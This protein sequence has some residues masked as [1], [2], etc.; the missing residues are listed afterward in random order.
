MRPLTLLFVLGL[1]M[2]AFYACQE[3]R[4]AV[5]AL[6]QATMHL[7][8]EAMKGM[9]DLNRVSRGLKQRLETLDSLAPQRSAIKDALLQIERAD[10]DMNNWMMQYQSPTNLKAAEAQAYLNGQKTKIE[11]NWADIKA[12][13]ANG[14]ALLK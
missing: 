13:I 7:H 5:K 1:M 10:T 3:D 4:A 11:K 9:A 2:T 14:E 6:E 12:A 8:D